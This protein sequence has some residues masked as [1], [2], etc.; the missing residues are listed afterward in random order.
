MGLIPGS[1][2]CH[3]EGNDKPLWYSCIENPMNSIK[4]Q[5]DMTPDNEPPRPEGIQYATG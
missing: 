3:G 2:R 4:R 1:G 5:K